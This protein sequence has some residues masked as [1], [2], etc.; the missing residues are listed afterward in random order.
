[1]ILKGHIPSQ[2]TDLVVKHV[3]ERWGKGGRE[4]LSKMGSMGS[5]PKL[6]GELSCCLPLA[7]RKILGIP[8]G[9]VCI[10]ACLENDPLLLLARYTLIVTII[11]NTCRA[12][13]VCQPHSHLIISKPYGVFII[14]IIT[15]LPF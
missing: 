3:V 9:K 6:L 13:T 5:D 10:S 4:N 14:G 12:L 1:M 7:I 2:W 8:G 15:I 11:A